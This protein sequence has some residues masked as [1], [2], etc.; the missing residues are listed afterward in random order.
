MQ[1]V[2][3]GSDLT[4][5]V[6]ASDQFVEGDRSECFGTP[7]LSESSLKNTDH[8]F[9]EDPDQVQTATGGLPKHNLERAVL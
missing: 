3:L 6:A 7:Q 4:R 2:R 1:A 9:Q 8:N 5:P